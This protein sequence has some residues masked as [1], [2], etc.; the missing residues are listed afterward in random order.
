MFCFI[1]L[2][3]HRCS[4]CLI[5]YGC[6]P[7]IWVTN[8]TCFELVI[9][10][11][12]IFSI[13]FQNPQG[14]LFLALQGPFSLGQIQTLLESQLTFWP[15]CHPLTAS[16]L[17]ERDFSELSQRKHIPEG[18]RRCKRQDRGRVPKNGK[19]TCD[20]VV[21]VAASDSACSIMTSPLA[22]RT[23]EGMA[24]QCP[25]ASQ[26]FRTMADRLELESCWA[27]E[28]NLSGSAESSFQTLIASWVTAC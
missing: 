24:P 3:I 7:K 6:H 1:L 17:T 21:V 5:L 12:Q 19:R 22:G 11:S 20:F 26:T 27:E 4:P 25:L 28:R 8:S 13:V 2:T 9:S 14:L 15:L 23:A 10:S 16:F 18:V